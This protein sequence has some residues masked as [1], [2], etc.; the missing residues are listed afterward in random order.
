VLA[1]AVRPRPAARPPEAVGQQ[2]LQVVVV[3]TEVAV[4]D[5]LVVVGVRPGL[6][7]QPGQGRRFRVRRL[8]GRVLAVAEGARQGREQVCA[9]PQVA[10]VRIRAVLKEH[11]RDGGL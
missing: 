8:V 2:Q 11:P 6:E 7:Q 4:V 1:E 3:R 10:G 5:R 9:V